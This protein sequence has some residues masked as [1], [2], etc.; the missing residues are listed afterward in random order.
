MTRSLRGSQ[1]LLIGMTETSLSGIK[2]PRRTADIFVLESAFSDYNIGMRRNV[3]LLLALG[4]TMILIV[5]SSKR[6]LSF[7]DTSERV[8]GEEAQLEKLRQENEELKRELEYKKSQR[9]AEEEIRN[10]L[11]LAKEGEEV[12][13]IPKDEEEN[14]EATDNKPKLPNWRKWQILIFGKG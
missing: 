9:F 4:I 7:K 3:M 5:S 13:V 10:K 11:G 1:A 12:F 6:I 2:V 8:A 14:V